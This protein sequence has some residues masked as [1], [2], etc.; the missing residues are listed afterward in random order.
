[1]NHLLKTSSNVDLFATVLLQYLAYN[2]PMI[3]EG[4]QNQSH[5][6]FGIECSCEKKDSNYP[7]HTNHT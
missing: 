4:W 2:V 7:L 5:I 6:M 1:M 3:E